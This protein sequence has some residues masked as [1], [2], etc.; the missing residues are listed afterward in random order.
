MLGGVE[1]DCRYIEGIYG[2]AEG[3]VIGFG[4]A[5]GENDLAWGRPQKVSYGLAG[6]FQRR[7]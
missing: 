4:A 6:F 3:I 2:L 1:E 7:A 5:A